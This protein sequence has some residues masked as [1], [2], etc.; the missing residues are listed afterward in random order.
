MAAE[1]LVPG[2]RRMEWEKPGEH[3]HYSW[4]AP[5]EVQAARVGELRLLANPKVPRQWSFSL[6]LRAEEVYRWDVR[7]K[8]SGH[9]NPPGC[10]PGF[11]NKVPE[12]EH[13]H[14]WVEGLAC[15]CARPLGG[16]AASDHCGIFE[17]FCTRTHVRFEPE[18][19]APEAFEQMPL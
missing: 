6:L 2:T 16:L 19:I 3:R 13:E 12:R 8:P 11:P 9:E 1:K 18:Y 5:I 10:P 7:P 17:A 4:D 15:K 14:V